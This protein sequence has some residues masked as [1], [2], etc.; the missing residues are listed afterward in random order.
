MIKNFEVITY[1]YGEGLD[2]KQDTFTLAEA[3]ALVKYYIQDQKYDKA[4]IFDYKKEKVVALFNG[5]D[6]DHFAADYRNSKAKEY[7]V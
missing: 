7:T 6:Q 5:F 3:K 1:A 4:A 2:E